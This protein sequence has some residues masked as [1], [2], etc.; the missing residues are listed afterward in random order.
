[1]RDLVREYMAYLQVEK[2]LAVNSLLSYRRDIGKLQQWALNCNSEVQDLRREEI[3]AWSRWLSD[4]GLSPRSVA[5]AISTAR[6]FYSFLLRD[7]LIKTD[8]MAGIETPQAERAMPKVMTC[9][10]I[11]RLLLALETKTPESIRDRTILELLYAT[12][13]RVSELTAL[14][15]GDI[16][17]E[18]GLLTCKGK[19]SKYRRV[20]VGRSALKWLKLY[21]NARLVLLAGGTST[22]L[23][24][25][26]SGMG[27]TRQQVWQSL[28]LRATHVGLSGLSPHVLRHSFATHIMQR[29][30]DSRTVQSL[31]GH[32]D[33]STTQ[34]Y[35]HMT[36]R[37]LRTTYDSFHPRA[38]MADTGEQ[39]RSK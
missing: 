20:P 30:A 34:L 15:I 26:K 7:K 37:H 29:G 18:Q 16:D 35:T 11:E 10:E 31:L 25:S 23:F 38:N 28:K 13:L 27:L 21:I 2:G 19:G 22:V 1:M 5:R 4:E 39:N 17:S 24:I 12:G 3:V 9:E 14:Q 33:L 8:P 32:S 6:G 36:S